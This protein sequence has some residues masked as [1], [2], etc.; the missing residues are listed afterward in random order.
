M[1]AE[2]KKELDKLTFEEKMMNKEYREYLREV[3]LVRI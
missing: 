1:T 2:R 3:S